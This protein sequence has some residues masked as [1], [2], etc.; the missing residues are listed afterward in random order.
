MKLRDASNVLKTVS[1]VHMRDAANVLRVAP[2][3]HM[4]DAANAL[5]SAY[6]SGGG[7]GGGGSPPV[8]I[9]PTSKSTVSSTQQSNTSPFVAAFSGTP[10]SIVWS[11]EDVIGGTA[12]VFSGQGT[13]TAQITVTASDIG[14]ASCTIRCTVVIAGVTY[15]STATKQHTLRDLGGGGGGGGGNP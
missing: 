3:I 8:S 9:T 10:T 5:K 2:A 4:R 7:G 15:S 11:V 14:T 13:S 1:A 6:A 12:Q